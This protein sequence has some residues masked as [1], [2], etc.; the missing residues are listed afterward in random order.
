[1]R[2]KGRSRRLSTGGFVLLAGALVM[3]SMSMASAS[4]S[5]AKAPINIEAITLAPIPGFDA[6]QGAVSYWDYV[7]AHGGI[8]GHQVKLTNCFIGTIISQNPDQ[9]ASCAQQAV[10]NHDIAVNGSFDTYPSSALPILAAAKIADFGDFPLANA[11]YTNS[12]SYPDITPAIFAFAGNAEELVKI[13]HCKK[14]GLILYSGPVAPAIEAAT[15]AGT[16]YAGGKEVAPVAISTTETDLAPAVAT[17][18]S[19]GASCV[20]DDTQ[21]AV[22]LETAIQQSGQQMKVAGF[23]PAFA[24]NTIKALGSA[25]N[26]IYLDQTAQVDNQVND[27]P[28]YTPQEK[29]FCA[30]MTQYAPNFISYGNSEWPGYNASVMFDIVATYMVNHNMALTAKSFKKA[31]PLVG[32]I[33]TGFFSGVSF[34]HNGTVKGYPRIHSYAVNYEVI[35]NGQIV[36]ITHK[37]YDVSAALI[38]YPIA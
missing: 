7:N 23:G 3:S 17:I 34:A 32:T 20:V 37:S 8:G 5:Q 18:E 6:V 15:A 4:Q 12:D 29:Q 25:A 14:V 33:K 30:I 26:G 2:S 11:D 19:E 21:E 16:K 9:A 1:M 27:C 36:P 31:I 35:T 38:K 10:A 28:G 13:G 22:A 24:P